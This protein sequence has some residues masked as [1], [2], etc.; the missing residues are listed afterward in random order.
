VRQRASACV[1]IRQHTSAYVDIRPLP[2]PENSGKC[3]IRRETLSSL[4]TTASASFYISIRQHTS[5]QRERE[6][7]VTSPLTKCDVGWMT[8]ASLL[9]TAMHRCCRPRASRA[10]FQTQAPAVPLQTQKSRGLQSRV[11]PSSPSSPSSASLDIAG[12][13]SERGACPPHEKEETA[14]VNSSHNYMP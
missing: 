4:V 6:R 9:P 7:E 11:S 2:S 3:A 5:R 14:A 1:S 12:D 10:T 8:Y 13:A